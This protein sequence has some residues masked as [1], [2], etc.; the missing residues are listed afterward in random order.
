[1]YFPHEKFSLMKFIRKGGIVKKAWLLEWK[2]SLQKNIKIF[3]T[4]IINR[5]IV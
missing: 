1:M 5:N 3:L 4:T 2:K